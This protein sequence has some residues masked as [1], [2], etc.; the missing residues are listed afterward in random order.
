MKPKKFQGKDDQ[1]SFKSWWPLYMTWEKASSLADYGH[2][3]DYNETWYQMRLKQLM[4]NDHIEPLT[5]TVWKDRLHG[6][7]KKGKPIRA[8]YLKFASKEV[9]VNWIS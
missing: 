7:S 2:W 3:T 9:N 4:M 5:E 1:K 6:S 8:N